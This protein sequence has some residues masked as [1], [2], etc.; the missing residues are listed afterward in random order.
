[1]ATG[2]YFFDIIGKYATPFVFWAITLKLFEDEEEAPKPNAAP[3]KGRR[4]KKKG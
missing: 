1:M 4:R 3:A 2:R